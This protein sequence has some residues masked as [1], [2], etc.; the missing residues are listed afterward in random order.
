[1]GY[2]EAM[3]NIRHMAKKDTADLANGQI[4]QVRIQPSNEKLTKVLP[5]RRMCSS[6]VIQESLSALR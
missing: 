3:D 6:T 4:R 1:M 2:L 5:L